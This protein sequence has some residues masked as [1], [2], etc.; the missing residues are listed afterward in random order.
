MNQIKRLLCA[1]GCM[2]LLC[3][4]SG[5]VPRCPAAVTA[6]AETA[7]FSGTCGEHITWALD[8]TGTLTLRGTGAMEDYYPGSSAPWIRLSP[9]RVVIEDGITQIG[10]Y[11]FCDCTAL[12]EISIPDSSTRSKPT[13]RD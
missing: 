11:A 1:V 10:D 12:E 3:L 9:A 7:A 4:P 13:A 8:D 2:G 6:F 5:A